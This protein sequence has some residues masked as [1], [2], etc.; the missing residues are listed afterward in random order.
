MCRRRQASTPDALA[1][2][3][4]ALADALRKGL[5]SASSRGLNGHCAP[6]PPQP[7]QEAE[8]R[9]REHSTHV[10]AEGGAAQHSTPALDQRGGG[11]RP[12]APAAA[13]VNGGG[14]EPQQQGVAWAG[15]D[16]GAHAG[17]DSAGDS[18]GLEA[19]LRQQQHGSLHLDF[20]PFMDQ[21]PTSVRCAPA[22]SPANL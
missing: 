7:Q 4:A 19:R 15:A 18:L 14:G 12:G 11:G 10:D 3:R 21:G 6:P 1:A 5:S 8:A 13:L 17:G 16:G 9:S 20:R 22:C 2:V